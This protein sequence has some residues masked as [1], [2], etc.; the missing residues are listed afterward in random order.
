MKNK[1]LLCGLVLSTSLLFAQPYGQTHYPNGARL[2]SGQQVNLNSN[3]FLM[4]GIH[5]QDIV[6]AETISITKTDIGGAYNSTSSE[7]R[8]QYSL[9]RTG[10]NCVPTG[11][12]V[13][14]YAGVSVIEINPGPN[15]EWYAMASA[16]DEGVMF[17]TLDNTGVPVATSVY[18]FSSPATILNKPT[19][20]E[21]PTNPGDFYICGMFDSVMYVIKTDIAGSI[22]WSGYY[23]A[24]GGMIEPRDMIISAHNNNLIIVG[25][26]TPDPQY[27]RFS[28]GFLLDLDPNSGSVNIFVDY[29]STPC[30]WFNA[31]ENSYSS[32]GGSGYIVGGYCDPALNAGGALVMKLATNGSI[33]WNTLLEG[34][35]QG[36]FTDEVLDVIE[37]H[38]TSSVSSPTYEYYAVARSV[39]LSMPQYDNISV[40]KLNDIGTPFPGPNEFFYPGT[41]AA[42][43]TGVKLDH[44]NPGTT[45][46][47]EGLHIFA[48]DGDNFYLIEAYFNGHTGCNEFF[49]P[50]ITE[51]GPNDIYPWIG[52]YGSFTQCSNQTLVY[53]D[54]VYTPNQICSSNSI[55]SGNN[56]RTTGIK[57]LNGSGVLK[58]YPNPSNGIYTLENSSECSVKIV[59]ALGEVIYSKNFAAGQNSINIE[60]LPA[61]IY[62]LWSKDSSGFSAL[63]LIKE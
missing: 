42:P 13:R 5:G 34:T 49:G 18:K 8:K 1:I 11:V 47:D 21:S 31:I 9:M 19:L 20:I 38:N 26:V 39:N 12:D 53:G 52:T 37:R 40:F 30:N 10:S 17:S 50:A 55:S 2:Y 62:T 25:H 22:F 7:F 43:L 54:V 45:G 48:N 16:Y 23:H 4:G 57:E 63:Q 35:G 15:G 44:R 46:F 14:D 36:S 61:G 51:I 24:G 56:Q 28:D 27:M 33:I 58:A 60:S 29:S 3:G 6:E 41:S 59:N 32:T